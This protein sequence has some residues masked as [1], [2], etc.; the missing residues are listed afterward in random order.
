MTKAAS[1]RRRKD[2]PV[3]SGKSNENDST[4]KVAP[5]KSKRRCPP[6]GSDEFLQVSPGASSEKAG[7][8]L[9]YLFTVL[10][11]KVEWLWKDRVPLGKIVIE[12]GDPGLG[13]STLAAYIASCVSTGAAFPGETKT[14]E[15]AGV[16]LLS[17][18]D[19]LA[20]TIRPR[21]DAIGADTTKIVALTIPN[22]SI[23]LPEH[24][25]ALEKAVDEVG[26]KLIVID[27]FMA[28]LGAVDSHKDQDIRRALNPL[29][30][31]AESK[32]VAII[33]IRHLNKGSGRSAIY[34]GGGSIAIMAA[35]RVGLLVGR[36]PENAEHRILAISKSNV[37]RI[38]TSM[39]WK[40]E[41]APNGVGRVKWLGEAENISAEDLVSDAQGSEGRS[42][43]A[44]AEG[45]LRDLLNDDR[46][47]GQI[48]IK[49]AQSL[50]LDFDISPKTLQRAAKSIGL[51][52]GR[53]GFGRGAKGYWAR[54]PNHCGQPTQTGHDENEPGGNRG[55]KPKS[56]GSSPGPIEDIDNVKTGAVHN[57]KGAS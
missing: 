34:R 21:L 30:K 8:K 28:F 37:G 40:I 53:D 20:D 3:T 17:A 42:K 2:S 38:A 16:V 6:E 43:R 18:E 26:A 1:S 33:L 14:R 15:P 44:Q 50:A 19:G 24:M 39:R 49:D 36:D 10:A 12:D 4:G 35:A 29:A 41:E 23:R 51:I 11:E 57:D 52:A 56:K 48:T 22:G 9:T 27:P 55:S 31:L 25:S 45:L 47:S 32:N 7:H 46:Y 54:D 13:K 5:S